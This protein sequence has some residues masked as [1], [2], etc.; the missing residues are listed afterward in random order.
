MNE[1]G[2]ITKDKWIKYNGEWYYLKPNGYMAANEWAKDSTGWCWLDSS[3]KMVRR[4]WITTG[5]ATDYIDASGHMVTGNQTIDG[6]EY[7][8][9]SSGV[10]ITSSSGTS[11]SSSSSGGSEYG[12]TPA[13]GAD[14]TYVVNT[15]SDKFHYPGCSWVSRISSQNRQ[16]VCNS[17][18]ELIDLGYAPCQVCLG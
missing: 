13:S 16:D 12:L 7:Q 2:K 4:R 9:S 8:F 5:G 10:L 17:Y 15:N 14:V 18:S 6:K 11:S 1:S 3:G